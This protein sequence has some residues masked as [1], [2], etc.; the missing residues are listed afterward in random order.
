[1][2]TVKTRATWLLLSGTHYCGDR[3]LGDMDVHTIYTVN[4]MLKTNK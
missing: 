1:M 2:M 3:Q 4:E